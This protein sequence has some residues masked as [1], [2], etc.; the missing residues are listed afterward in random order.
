M[1]EAVMLLKQTLLRLFSTFVATVSHVC[2]HSETGSGPL[3]TVCSEIVIYSDNPLY[4]IPFS[5]R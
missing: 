3:P 2:S 4:L 5:F 1:T